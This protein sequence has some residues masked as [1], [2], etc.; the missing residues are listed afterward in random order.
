[1]AG[2]GARGQGTEAEGRGHCQD[3]EG[4]PGSAEAPERDVAPARGVHLRNPR[5]VTHPCM[6]RCL[7]L[8]P[9]KR[10][11]RVPSSSVHTARSATTGPHA[12][13]SIVAERNRGVRGPSRGLGP[14]ARQHNCHAGA[15]LRGAG[16]VDAP[17]VGG[18]YCAHDGE[19]EARAAAPTRAR[20][21]ESGRRHG[22]S[23]IPGFRARRPRRP[24]PPGPGGP[25]RASAPNRL[26]SC[27]G[28]RCARGCAAPGRGDR[29]PRAASLQL[30]LPA[31]SADRRSV[32]RLSKKSRTNGSSSMS[33]ACTSAPSSARASKRRS[34]T[35]RS[36][37]T[38][39]M[40]AMRSVRRTS[41]ALGAAWREST[42]SWPRMTVSG[43]RSSCDA[44][45]TNARWPANASSRRSSMWSKAS[46][47]TRISSGG[48]WA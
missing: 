5:A 19:P 47:S 41:S 32:V 29:D 8:H 24:A 26:R 37:R 13:S 38:S 40:R 12:P 18:G 20:P 28:S 16:R 44:S 48:P 21:G 22:F 7:P 23:R 45:A 46:A 27:A 11:M 42:S 35:R 9:P 4:L 36:M 33:C 6:V 30:R 2:E 15:S 3:D 43:V 25:S 14:P 39:S 31:R 10:G 1:M 34:S 17:A